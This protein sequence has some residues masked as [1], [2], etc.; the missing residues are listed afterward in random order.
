MDHCKKQKAMHGIPD[1]AKTKIKR[2]L[3]LLP[4]HKNTFKMACA[5]AG[6]ANHY[7]KNAGLNFFSQ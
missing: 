7:V 5:R 6:S 1:R 2:R 4:V 3:K